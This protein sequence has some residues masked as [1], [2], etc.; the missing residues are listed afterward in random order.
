TIVDVSWTVEEKAPYRPG[1]FLDHWSVNSA[2][3][4]MRSIFV[5]TVPEAFQ[6]RIVERNLNFKRTEQV[7]EKRKTFTWAASNVE[8]VR[9]E[10]FA[11]DSNDVLMS[12][13]IAPPGSW[14]DIARWYSGLAKDRY[15]LSADVSKRVDSVVMAAKARTR[16]DTL[17]AL[18]RWVA[19]DVR[20]VSVSLGMGGYQPRLPEQVLSTGFGDCKDKATLFV[21]AARKYGIDADPV[22]LSS[23]GA[24]NRDTPSIYQFNHA[25]A[26]VR[27][28]KSWTFTDL[29]AESIPYG[30]IPP[31][32]QGSLGIVVLPD[33]RGEEITFPLTPID[34]NNS[35]VRLTGELF[36]SGAISAHVV[37]RTTGAASLGTR[38]SF[39]S[40]MDSTNRAGALRALGNAY[41]KDGSAD[42]LVTFNGKDLSADA[43][44]SFHVGGSD[45]LK[46][47]G[48]V[49]L[50]TVPAPF[51]GPA[52]GFNNMAKTLAASPKRK[53]TVDVGNVI[54][55]ITTFREIQIT[56]PLGW[57]AELPKNVVATS[58]AGR[59]EARYAQEG[60][61]LHITQRLTG[62]RGVYAPERIAEV[63]AWF[64]AV[65]ADDVEFIQ[66]KPAA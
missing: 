38:H 14:N 42:S 27:D 21:A 26:A 16:T 1:D 23:F 17:R 11:A 58:I 63:I 40:P 24:S 52:Q 31:S 13:T 19:Q 33:G 47:A 30:I 10:M 45:V 6:P 36:A 2:S 28:G 35:I 46:S 55:P 4:I 25:I 43:V 20:Y 22:L 18:H 12:V 44:V 57:T 66:L 34:S 9:G 53:F 56:M 29:T 39:Y 62:A 3:E 61:V 54:G 15:A 60:R 7:A 8:R 37:D 64:K 51:R 41:F 59:Y 65:A 32:Y 48:N 50:F 49:K 5:V